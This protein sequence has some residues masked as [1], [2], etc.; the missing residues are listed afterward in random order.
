MI[1]DTEARLVNLTIAPNDVARILSGHMRITNLPVDA[2][3]VRATAPYEIHGWV[4]TLR[5]E[6]FD[7][8]EEGFHIPAF[9]ALCEV[10]EEP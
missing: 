2:R 10:K 6:S 3:L 4:L 5:H 1:D 9:L 8:V 7:V